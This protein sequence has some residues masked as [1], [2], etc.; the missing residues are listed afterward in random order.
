MGAAQ[1]LAPLLSQLLQGPP[2]LVQ[3]LWEGGSVSLPLLS[4]SC[5]QGLGEGLTG[6]GALGT[7]DFMFP[8]SSAEYVYHKGKMSPIWRPEHPNT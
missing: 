8:A 5:S 4:H 6:A 3:L 2:A 7:L 1:E